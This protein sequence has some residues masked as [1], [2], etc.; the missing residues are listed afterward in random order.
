MSGL[1]LKLLLTVGGDVRNGKEKFGAFV[2]FGCG[3]HVTYKRNS[4]LQ[5]GA[6][7]LELSNYIR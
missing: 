6:G 4:L 2:G 5:C 7:Y 3:V 1:P